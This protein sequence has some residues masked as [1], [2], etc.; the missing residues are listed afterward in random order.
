M[1][2]AGIY[3]KCNLKFTK[4]ILTSVGGETSATLT[5]KI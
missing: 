2:V 3:L 1:T 5:L 4:G